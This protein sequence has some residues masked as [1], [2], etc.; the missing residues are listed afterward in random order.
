MFYFIKKK[1]LFDTKELFRWFT[2]IVYKT[3]WSASQYT[4]DKGFIS[5]ILNHRNKTNKLTERLKHEGN[6]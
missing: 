5:I 6:E 2:Q 1:L 4:I 3:D